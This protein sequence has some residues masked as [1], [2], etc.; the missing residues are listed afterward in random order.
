M[1]RGTFG[2]ALLLIGAVLAVIGGVLWKHED[3]RIHRANQI[4]ALVA[5][6]DRST[7]HRAVTDHARSVVLFTVSGA[8]GLFGM[9]LIAGMSVGEWY[10]GATPDAE[11]D[12]S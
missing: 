12:S 8:D 3:A 7:Y 2:A 1:S 9:L 6:G 5:A 11:A 10:A 4:N